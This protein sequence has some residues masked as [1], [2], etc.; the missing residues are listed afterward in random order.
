MVRVA[1][2]QQARCFSPYFCVLSLPDKKPLAMPEI[3]K[4][5][6]PGREK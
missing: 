1:V 4:I 3:Y 6:V 2:T 5:L